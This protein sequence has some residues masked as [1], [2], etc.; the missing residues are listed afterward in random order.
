MNETAS[1]E[2]WL[3]ANLTE[4]AASENPS[5]SLSYLVNPLGEYWNSTCIT[6]DVADIFV[7]VA[8]IAYPFPVRRG[9]HSNR[10]IRA[11]VECAVKCNFIAIY[12]AQTIL[13][14][15]LLL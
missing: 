1:L 3:V 2:I 6:Y 15:R 14:G 11:H 10:S 13:F 5:L 8:A 9:K 4:C 7:V 12:D